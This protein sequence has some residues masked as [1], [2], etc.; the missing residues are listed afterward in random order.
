[1]GFLDKFKK[2]YYDK[3]YNSP[4]IKIIPIDKKINGDLISK[5]ST[6]K[7]ADPAVK[8]MVEKPKETAD[9]FKGRRLES[10]EE[11]PLKRNDVVAVFGEQQTNSKKD[12]NE[13]DELIK[14]PSEIKN[15]NSA[16]VHGEKQKE[17]SLLDKIDER[18]DKY[19]YWLRER[20]NPGEKKNIIT[21]VIEDTSKVRKYKETVTKIISKIINDNKEDLF[22][23]YRVGFNPKHFG[24]IN[25]ENIEKNNIVEQL[26][27]DNDEPDTASLLHEVLKHIKFKINNDKTQFNKMEIADK[28]YE[29]TGYSI[30]FIGIANFHDSTNEISSEILKEFKSN[31]MIKTI[32][33]FCIDDI[34]AINAAAIGFPVIGHIE[35][36][37]YK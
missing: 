33:Y 27:V 8:V 9:I 3:E 10:G 26:L 15:V 29:I 37:F 21:M 16:E 14:K 2:K 23:I 32:K 12:I 20:R 11:N 36:N 25:S 31:K 19:M 18:D 6:S 7:N 24:I 30:I 13:P 34:S 35:A 17:K 28:K 4:T 5:E 22:S 1:M